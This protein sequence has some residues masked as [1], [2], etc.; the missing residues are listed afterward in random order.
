MDFVKSDNYE[1]SVNTIKEEMI[2]YYN[3]LNLA[4]GGDSKLDHYRSCDLWSIRDDQDV[5]F[6]MTC[7]D[8]GDFYLAELHIKENQRNKGYGAKSLEIA[9]GIASKLGYNQIRIR[10]FKSS[11]AYDLYLRSGFSLEKELPYTF[12]LV[13]ST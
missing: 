2:S 6:A 5:G 10:V 1:E 4:W 13:S 3:D 7:D 11:P 12:Q 9:K 8:K